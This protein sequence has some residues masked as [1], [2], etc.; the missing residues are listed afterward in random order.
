M[1]Q[2]ISFLLLTLLLILGCE[3]VTEVSTPPEQILNKQLITLAT[4]IGLGV[5]SQ[6]YYKDIN[7]SQG[8]EF[9]Q[10][11]TYQSSN[12]SVYQ[13][14]DLD[15]SNG[16][17]SGIKS[18]SMTFN[19]DGAAMEF[20]P[21][22]QF[23]A[24]VEYT[25]KITGLDLTGINPA[26]LDFVYIDANGNMYAVDYDYVTMDLSDGMLK[27]KNAILPHFSRYGFVN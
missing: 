3:Q 7:G 2:L 20:G 11:Y 12:G 5:E 26:T 21:A 27:V 23:Q 16:A 17:F 15:F 19:T 4:P 13:F 10:S 8:G 18:I 6:T 9:Q 1:R 24:N 22:M 25:Y 14:S